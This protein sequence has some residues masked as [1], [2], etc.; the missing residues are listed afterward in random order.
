MSGKSGVTALSTYCT[1]VLYSR[2]SYEDEAAKENRNEEHRAPTGRGPVR[3]TIKHLLPPAMVRAGNFPTR[4]T[5]DI[6]VSLK[7][8]IYQYYSIQRVLL[9]CI[10]KSRS[11]LNSHS[12]TGAAFLSL[13]NFLYM[14][15]IL[16]STYVPMRIKK[17]IKPINAAL[18]LFY[19]CVATPCL[20]VNFKSVEI[21]D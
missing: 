21:F 19:G 4:P 11:T 15:R 18:V 9:E 10:E 6:C 12:H 14:G 3:S 8:L 7:S 1:I 2:E 13:G 16:T 17:E 20:S 5:F